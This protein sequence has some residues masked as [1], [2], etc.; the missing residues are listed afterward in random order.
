MSRTV[1]IIIHFCLAGLAGR[2]KRWAAKRHKKICPNGNEAPVDDPEECTLGSEEEE[3][4]PDMAVMDSSNWSLEIMTNL[5]R[6]DDVRQKR[7]SPTNWSCAYFSTLLAKGLLA[8]KC[9]STG[10]SPPAL[11]LGSC[12]TPK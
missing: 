8:Q 12:S 7:A 5:G 3:V 1:F 10:Q 6:I 11:G 2:I 9:F 4:A